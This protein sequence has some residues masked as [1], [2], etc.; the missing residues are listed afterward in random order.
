MFGKMM[1]VDSIS[2]PSYLKNNTDLKN[3]NNAKMKKGK[4]INK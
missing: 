1:M 4:V 2:A 3:E